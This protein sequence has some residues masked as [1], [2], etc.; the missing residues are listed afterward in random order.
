MK[1]PLFFSLL[2]PGLRL[3]GS[4]AQSS[5]PCPP[6]HT[7]WLWGVSHYLKGQAVHQPDLMNS[8]RCL[9]RSSWL[10][11]PSQAKTAFLPQLP[12]RCCQAF[13]VELSGQFMNWLAPVP[14]SWP[15]QE[16]PEQVSR[17]KGTLQCAFPRV[18]ALSPSEPA[19]RTGVRILFSMSRTSKTPKA[20][21]LPPGPMPAPFSPSRPSPMLVQSPGMSFPLPL[22]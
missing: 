22:L 6:P 14:S 21:C 9:S 13:P 1:L 3:P 12:V 18:C 4:P 2:E 5:A 11:C 7:H 8:G 19:D 10:L 17:Q 20:A 15:R 16:N